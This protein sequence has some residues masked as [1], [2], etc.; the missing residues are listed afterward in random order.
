[1]ITQV[2][3]SIATAEPIMLSIS[4]D[5]PSIIVTGAIGIGSILTSIAVVWVT[6]VNQKSQGKAKL[7]EIRKGDLTELKSTAAEFIGVCTNIRSC[8]MNNSFT[9]NEFDQLQTKAY[10]LQANIFLS[11]K[12]DTQLG[13][14]IKRLTTKIID[15]SSNFKVENEIYLELLSKLNAKFKLVLDERWVEIKSALN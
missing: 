13:K 9:G 10:T 14:D 2:K 4:P 7:A 3:T 12:L 15:E 5:W 11:I 8:H 1:M 6:R